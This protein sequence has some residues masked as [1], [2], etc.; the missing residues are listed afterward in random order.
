MSVTKP[1]GTVQYDAVLPA[2]LCLFAVSVVF[3]VLVVILGT[4]PGGK[5]G[6]LTAAKLQVATEENNRSVCPCFPTGWEYNS[7]KVSHHFSCLK[8]RIH[9]EKIYCSKVR[10]IC[11]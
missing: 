11:W 7:T 8:A 2:L 6:I 3:C 9:W 10:A 1:I 5:L 4:V